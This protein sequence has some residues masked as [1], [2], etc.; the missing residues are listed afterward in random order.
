MR[1]LILSILLAGA[2][3]SP[4]LAQD[5][6]R[7]RQDEAQSNT[8][9][10]NEDRGQTREQR[11]EA[12]EE[13]RAERS[14]SGGN[15]ERMQQAQQQQLL[16]QQ[17]Q[18]Q[19]AARQFEMRQQAGG[20]RGGRD[21]SR[22][23]GGNVAPQQV[24]QQRQAERYRGY[25]GGY[26]DTPGQVQQTSRTGGWSRDRGNWS[27]TR[28]GDFRQREAQ[29]QRYRDSSR[30]AGGGWNRDWRNDRRYDWRGYRNNHR[31]AFHLG[32]YY[33]PFGYGYQPF[34][35]GYDL[36]PLYYGQQYWIDPSLYS[37]PFPP[38][39]TAWVRYWNDAVLVDLYSGQVVDVI[40]NFFW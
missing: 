30:W 24:E 12:R 16:Q 17:Q 28:D 34:N 14:N 22:Y 13:V 8:Q 25:R 3:A 36:P 29:Q 31:S 35:I 9:Q 37:L 39:G 32:I 1:K 6:G 2:A 18:Q 15:A 38:P 40:H 27:Q 21:G 11:R 19:Q 5:H 20:Q 33:D 26:A 23:Q 10:A 4:A 7:W